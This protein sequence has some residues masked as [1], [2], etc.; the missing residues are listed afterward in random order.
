LASLEA[1]VSNRSVLD[2]LPILRFLPE[3]VRTRIVR[4]F[5]PASFSFG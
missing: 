5:T 2:E 4:R 3:D 1:G